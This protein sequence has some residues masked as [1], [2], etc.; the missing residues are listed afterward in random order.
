MSKAEQMGASPSQLS[1]HT[2]SY[3]SPKQLAP[4]NASEHDREPECRG[5]PEQKN[6]L[7]SETVPAE[8]C[9]STKI[10]PCRAD[11]FLQQCSEHVTQNS[12]SVTTKLDFGSEGEHAEY[13]AFCTKERDAETLETEFPGTSSELSCGHVNTLQSFPVHVG[14]LAEH[15]WL[16]FEN[17]GYDA[18]NNQGST[19]RQTLQFSSSNT[20]EKGE[21]N[22]MKLGCGVVQSEL[23][24]SSSHVA[25]GHLEPVPELVTETSMEHH[26][27]VSNGN[28]SFPA[29]EQ[30]GLPHVHV[31]DH[32]K[33]GQ[34][35]APSKGLVRNTSQAGRRVKRTP[36]LLRKKY[37]LRSSTKSDRVLRSRSQ[38]KPKASQS[39]DNLANANSTMER[40]KKRG[41]RNKGK[42]IIY[43]EYSRIRKHLRYLLSRM[44]Y[45]QSLI[46][47]YSG[48]GW[49][50]L[51]LE[52]IKPEK[53]LQRA[54]S[55]ILR[56]KLKIRDLFQHID[57]LCSEGRFPD[58]LFDSEGQISSEDIFCAK[59]G[60]KD[61]TVHNDII[62]CDGV[63]D[64]GFH[65]FCLVPPLVK[66]D[67]PPD[68]EGWLCPA[69]DCKVDCLDLL[70]D[71]QGTDL[72]ISDSWEKV[73]P[74]AAG[75]QNGDPN[76]G[77]PSDDSDDNDYDPDG[78]EIDDRSE[79]DGSSSDES[80]FTSASEQLEAPPDDKL[81]LP[82]DD[83]EDDD[84]DPDAPDID[85]KEKLESSSSDFTSDSEDLT[86]AIC[87]NELSGV[88]EGRRGSNKRR[89][90]LGG[91][92]SLNTQLLSTSDPDLCNDGPAVV[93][94]KRSIER[95]DYKK[96]Y[97]ETYGNASSDS[98]DDEEYTVI[99]GPTKRRKKGGD[100]SVSMNGD[101]AKDNN[102][103][104]KEAQHTSARKLRQKA[105][106]QVTKKSPI[107]LHDAISPSNSS[108]KRVNYAYEEGARQRLHSVFKENQYPDR[109]TK[110]SLAKE[111]RLTYRQ[112][113][114]WFG[115]ARWSFFHS[116]SM[117]ASKTVSPAKDGSASGSGRP[118]K[119][120]A[121]RRVD[122]PAN[123]TQ[124]EESHKIGGTMAGSCSVDAKN[125]KSQE[126]KKRKYKTRKSR[127]R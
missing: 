51:S 57:S 90:D 40:K 61:L 20:A 38:E 101:A 19:S 50:G 44:N 111:L 123:G 127:T 10:L 59:C 85:E 124:T 80:D 28:S 5:L 97:D 104:P 60:S 69:C 88:K 11:E 125:R 56:R 126:S 72:S 23:A 96:L 78:P 26:G 99:D 7:G 116:S 93:S 73:F 36:K 24:E 22:L 25:G 42:R 9:K 122:A 54:T 79:G 35:E 15:S 92:Q 67:I 4:E 27:L 112:V 16:P 18:E 87:N 121:E 109:P 52:K 65:Q 45:E 13:G 68:D 103:N 105:S 110:E 89:S 6:E 100:V 3:S 66:E 48:E 70:N 34:S 81:G 119:T 102:Q 86:S 108:A 114:K 77:L 107:K 43:D 84:F 39:S 53:E 120:E 63:C 75:G 46:S 8:P 94:G 58:S 49:K 95:L 76:F 106:I 29:T 117:A 118:V 91:M 71:S 113:D 64:R 17:A 32:S 115:N 83:S 41:K 21:D 37:V 2:E 62:L 55:E 30:P 12:H 74:E 1:P 82:S 31:N 33:I 47:A 98:S 14:P